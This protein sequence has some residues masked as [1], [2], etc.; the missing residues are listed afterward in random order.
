MVQCLRL[1]KLLYEVMEGFDFVSR[2][3]APG[4]GKSFDECE[5][6]QKTEDVRYKASSRSHGKT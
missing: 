1:S 3:T 5:K 4:I 2:I 6:A